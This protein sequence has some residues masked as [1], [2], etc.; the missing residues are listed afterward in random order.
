VTRVTINETDGGGNQ[1]EGYDYFITFIGDDVGGDVPQLQVVD[2]N[3]ASGNDVKVEV[4]TIRDGNEVDGNVTL[5]FDNT[6]SRPAGGCHTKCT[7]GQFN[8][9]LPYDTRATALK[10]L[11]QSLPNVPAVD[12]AVSYIGGPGVLW[13]VTFTRNYGDTAELVCDN[14]TLSGTN[15]ITNPAC[16]VTTIQDG[17]FLN[18]TFRLKYGNV[19]T[20][21]LPW[22]VTREAL[23]IAIDEID[24]TFGGINVTRSLYLSDVNAPWEWTGGYVWTITWLGLKY[25]LPADLVLDANNTLL[26]GA[27]SES[28]FIGTAQNPVTFAELNA[29][30][31]AQVNEVQ[32]ID[33]LCTP[34]CEGGVT[35]TLY[36][37]I[38]PRLYPNSSMTDL[39]LA[40]HSLPEIDVV[41][42]TGFSNSSGMLCDGDG[43]T[44]AI[45]FLGNPGNVPPLLVSNSAPMNMT[46]LAS[47]GNVSFL[48][49]HGD[50]RNGT[51]GGMTRDGSRVLE[52]CSGRGLCNRQN[53][54]CACFANWGDS[55]RVGVHQTPGYGHRKDCSR[56]TAHIVDCPGSCLGRGV[57]RG[58]K[59]T[60]VCD[61][62]YDG[63]ACEKLKC[64]SSYAWF[65]EARPVSDGVNLTL[66]QSNTLQT[67]T[68]RQT[69]VTVYESYEL[70][71][72]SSHRLA[73]CG[74][75]GTCNG[76]TGT[77]S[78]T[79]GFGGTAC[80]QT[81]CAGQ[82]LVF[83]QG[84]VELYAGGC[85]GHGECM[86]MR[87]AGNNSRNVLTKESYVGTV[88]QY[89]KW[90]ADKNYG[91]AC[92]RAAYVGPVHDARADFFGPT[93]ER[94]VCPVSADPHRR[95]V[96]LDSQGFRTSPSVRSVYPMLGRDPTVATGVFNATKSY[97][98]QPRYARQRLTCNATGGFV[99]LD[100][101]GTLS[102]FVLWNTAVTGSLGIR[103]H[104][105]SMRAVREVA[106]HPAVPTRSYTGYFRK[107]T[108][109]FN[110][111]TNG[112]TTVVTPFNS[113]C[114][115]RLPDS[116]DYVDYYKDDLN[117]DSA[118][119]WPFEQLCGVTSA[120]EPHM[121]DV[122]FVSEHGR[123]PPIKILSRN[124]VGG[125]LYID[126][127]EA[128][129]RE[130][131][132]CSRRGACDENLGRC[133]C[134]PQYGSSDG[135]FGTGFLGDCGHLHAYHGLVT[136]TP[137]PPNRVV[138]DSGGAGTFDD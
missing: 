108:R 117:I 63:V 93:C 19:S 133:V 61:S 88:L 11:I 15:N 68:V 36:G 6:I 54:V 49:R 1:L 109:V 7:D 33:C 32:I 71:K 116:R 112:T 110:S 87:T 121:V 120:G 134:A 67:A 132:E 27:A 10:T 92:T 124:L 65:D 75:R 128:G 125:D 24:S 50:F 101:K 126:V 42:I 100:F 103:A 99:I 28:I 60:C 51:H 89:D 78:C 37:R 91:C 41:N 46:S 18:G 5:I 56:N 26:N 8:V 25:D 44:Y 80:G 34:P 119:C 82:S 55:D 74:G 90:D 94:A 45:T 127:L 40:L 122:T 17:Y 30:D 111:T 102:V 86:S 47:Q 4:S 31:T 136:P 16:N 22:N 138:L 69:A 79:R 64:P 70:G 23:A 2:L 77:C 13:F 62:L 39:Q 123:Q 98:E 12:V 97:E 113:T 21:E 73:T 14:S 29:D 129:S 96:A 106:V 48:L 137:L 59:F 3:I 95:R 135:R 107:L 43:A 53:G 84:G 85:N 76:A 114:T 20:G 72:V 9:T 130:A 131:V 35:L 81:T 57:C 104:L 118:E 115:H 105:E 52:E 58:P 38:L 83:G 66:V